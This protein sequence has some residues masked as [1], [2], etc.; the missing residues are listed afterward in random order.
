M[1][2]YVTMSW[3]PMDG[4]NQM[5]ANNSWKLHQ[6]SI[7]KIERPQLYYSCDNAYICA[8]ENEVLARLWFYEPTLLI[9]FKLDLLV[10]LQIWA[11]SCSAHKHK[12]GTVLH[13]YV[14]VDLHHHVGTYFQKTW[15]K[16]LWPCGIIQKRSS[17]AKAN[18]K[19]AHNQAYLHALTPPT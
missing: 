4:D 7:I 16:K 11:L 5:N 19:M 17:T 1:R 13:T 8:Q 6:Y 12:S 2:M 9:C 15:C 14:D 10:C 3:N 18:W